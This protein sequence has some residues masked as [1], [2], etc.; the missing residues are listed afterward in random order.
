MIRDVAPVLVHGEGIVEVFAWETEPGFA[1]H[2]LNYTNP[3]MLSGWF[4]ETYPVGEQH[5][6]AEL[7]DGV[8]GDRVELLRAGTSVPMRR[9]G[10]FVEFVVPGVRD[11]EV[12]VVGR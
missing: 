12:A 7:P 4:T 1:L 6:R 9:D 11:Y 3:N 8:R 2:L 5:V 10:R